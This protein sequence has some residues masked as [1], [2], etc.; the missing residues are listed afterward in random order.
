[1]GDP[2]QRR[3]MKGVDDLPFFT[4][5]EAIEKPAHATQWPIPHGVVEDGDLMEKFMER[6]IFKYLRAEPEDH[7]FLLTEPPVNTPENRECT[8]EIV[9][10]SFSVPGLSIAVQAVPALAASWTSR[11]VGEQ[12]LTGTGLGSGDGVSHVIPV[13]EGCGTGS[14]MKHIPIAGQDILFSSC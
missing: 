9:F 3:V 7:Y 4:G 8:A 11:Q 12:M 1:M 13:A 14:C 6:V 10:E 2:A 5:E